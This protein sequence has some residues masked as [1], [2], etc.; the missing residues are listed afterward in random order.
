MT[1]KQLLNFRCPG[2]LVE[3]IDALGRERYPA[4]NKNGCDRSKTLIDI[5][6]AGIQALTNGSVVI[7]I[8]S[9]AKQVDVRQSDVDV[10]A[11]KAELQA[12]ISQSLDERLGKRA[13]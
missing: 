3:E 13:A 8:Q 1:D 7:P 10:E 9:D 4:I 11:L 12:F 2:D 6:S 5:I